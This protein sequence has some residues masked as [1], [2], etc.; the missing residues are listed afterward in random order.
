MEHL[1]IRELLKEKGMTGKQLAEAVKVSPVTISN[2][3]KGNQFPKPEI[4]AAIAEALEVRMKDLFAAEEG[5]QP[6]Y[7]KEQDKY[8]KIGEIKKE[9]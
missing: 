5:M 3:V 7:I 1:R 2:I 9:K 8:I 4:L 6:I